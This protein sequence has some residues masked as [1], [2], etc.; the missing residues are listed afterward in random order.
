MDWMNW[1]AAVFVVIT[2]GWMAFDGVRALLIGDYFTP[3]EG[4]YAGKL[5]PWANL[6][7]SVGLEPRSSFVKIVFVIYGF[8]YLASMVALLAGVS[9]A[10]TAVIVLAILGLWYLPFGTVFNAVVIFLIWRMNS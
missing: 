9:W 10:S 2:G 5:G 8:L 3:S 4:E 7:R 6:V 1:L